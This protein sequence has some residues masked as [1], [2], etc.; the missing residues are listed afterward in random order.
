MTVGEE[1]IG[2]VLEVAKLEDGTPSRL[3]APEGRVPPSRGH[4]T[5][6]Q[7]ACM[8]RLSGCGSC[9][10]SLRRARPSM[11][12]EASHW[13]Q[14]D[15][16]RRGSRSRLGVSDPR[17]GWRRCVGSCDLAS[18]PHGSHNGH[19]ASSCTSRRVDRGSLEGYG[20]D[21]WEITPPV[22]RGGPFARRRPVLYSS[23][24]IMPE[25][26]RGELVASQTLGS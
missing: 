24:Q 17:S 11:P 14:C 2:Q 22:P 19:L 21:A 8:D 3:R 1:L 4:T 26:G 10:P 13:T 12:H 5:A 15:G 7:R 18:P 16:S 23:G 9:R 25:I 6:A 20:V